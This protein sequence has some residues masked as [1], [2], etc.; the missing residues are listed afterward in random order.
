MKVL[1][2]YDLINDKETIIIC[3][4]YPRTAVLRQM[5]AEKIENERRKRKRQIFVRKIKEA[6][7]SA[8]E[9]AVS[10]VAGLAFWHIISEKLLEIRGYEALGGEVIAAGFITFFYILCFRMDRRSDMDKK[11]I[12]DAIGF[13]IPEEL[14]ENAV[15]SARKN[16]NH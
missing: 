12:D 6:A 10:I 3:Y 5:D 11:M 4:R 15:I 13:E 14:Y 9:I 8:I 16:S 7:I 1:R 2:L